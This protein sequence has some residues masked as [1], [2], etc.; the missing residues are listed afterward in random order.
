MLSIGSRC[1]VVFF[2]MVFPTLSA[3]PWPCATLLPLL[4]VLQAQLD[5]ALKDAKAARDEAIDCRD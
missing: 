5:E 2:S 1:L 3:L 4:P